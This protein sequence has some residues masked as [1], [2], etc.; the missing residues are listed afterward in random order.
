MLT[1]ELPRFNNA[2]FSGATWLYWTDEKQPMKPLDPAWATSSSKT[3]LPVWKKKSMYVRDSVIHINSNYSSKTLCTAI[4]SI[5][6]KSYD[7]RQ[8]GT[9]KVSLVSNPWIFQTQ[10]QSCSFTVNTCVSWL[11]DTLRDW[12]KDKRFQTVSLH[13][14]ITLV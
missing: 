1:R 3:S 2:A 8:A 9:H 6:I 12:K 11:L 13:C 7:Y 4:V 5:Y 14:W 10:A